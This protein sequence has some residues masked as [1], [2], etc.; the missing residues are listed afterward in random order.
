MGKLMLKFG[1]FNQAEELYNELL[2]N[3]FNDSDRAYIYYKLG[4][5]KNN[6]DKYEEAVTFYEKVLEINRKT[7]PEDDASLAPTYRNI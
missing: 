3:P 1:D 2:D 5:L 6:Q 7:P 4:S